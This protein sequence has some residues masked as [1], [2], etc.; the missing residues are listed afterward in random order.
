MILKFGGNLEDITGSLIQASWEALQMEAGL[1][2]E[3]YDY[4][5][6]VQDYLTSSWLETTWAACRRAKIIFLDHLHHSS[7]AGSMTQ[8][9][10][11]PSSNKD[12]ETA[13]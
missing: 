6:L 3:I 1:S 2:G 10:S 7:H 9:S 4:P 8:K 5:K 11:E 13:S 12:T